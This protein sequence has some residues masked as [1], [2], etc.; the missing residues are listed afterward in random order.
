M[1]R[2]H[3]ERMLGAL[4]AAQAA[5]YAGE[6]DGAAVRELLT[7]GVRWHVPGR[8]A[9]AGTHEG[10]NAVLAY[11]ARRRDLAAQ[12]F[13]MHPGELL[14][15]DGEH[16]AAL[17]DGTATIAGEEHHW[18]TVGLYRVE[19]SR[20]AEVWLLPLDPEHFDRIWTNHAEQEDR[21]PTRPRSCSPR[22]AP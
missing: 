1:T 10:I 11:F 19:A 18:S 20:I 6:A 21:C 4:H 8:N 13:R 12:S 7:E 14:V 9:I 17:T 15:G 2:E 3:A 22:S 16:V 5:F